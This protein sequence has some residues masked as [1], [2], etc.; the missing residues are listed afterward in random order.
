MKIKKDIDYSIDSIKLNKN[1]I[2]LYGWAA[3]EDPDNK[4]FFD[5]TDS[6][7][8]YVKYRKDRIERK[9][10]SALKYGNRENSLYG[11]AL[12][13]PYKRNNFYTLTFY[14]DKDSV[15]LSISK[16]F[17]N[18]YRVHKA[19]SSIIH[20]K[21]LKNLQLK[22]GMD[23]NH[24]FKQTSPDK[25]E[26]SLEKH[27]KFPMNAP[28]FSIVVPLY[29]TPE[30]Y[31]KALIGSFLAQTYTNFEVCFADGS[32]EDK[33]L[34]TI[35]QKYS[36]HDSRIK[37]HFIGENR[38]IS[39][40]TNEALHMAT[41]DFIVLCDHD[42]LITPNAL[43]EFAKAI[44]DN[45]EC[46]SIY[47]DEDK[48]SS[49]GKDLFDPHFK[50]DFNEDM[51]T[52]VNYICH[53][54]G[55]R[56]S[57]VQKFGEFDSSYDGAQ[58]YDFIFRMTEHSKQIVHVA[59]ILY[60]WRTHQNSTSENPES[61]LYAY[62]AGAKAIRAHYHRVHPE[63]EIERIEKGISLGI[64]HTCF[65]FKEQ[66]FVSVIIPNKD[67][68]ADLD[69]VIRS[70]IQKSTWKSL[71]FIIVENNSTDEKTFT[72]YDKIEQEFP[73]VHVVRYK[74]TF[75]FSKICNFGASKAK[76]DYLLFMNNDV[77]LI[78]PDSVL[79]MMG[80][81]QRTDVGVV[82]CRL[83]YDDNTIQHAGVVVGIG[84]TADHVFR[85]HFSENDTYFNR[86][87]IAQDYSAV[88]A[89][90]MMVRRDAFEAAGRFD[91]NLAVAF[92]DIDFCL[93]V[94]SINKLV[95]YTPYASFHHYESKSRGFEDTFDKQVRFVSEIKVFLGKWTP[96]IKKGDPYYNPN[97]TVHNNDYSYRNLAIEEVGSTFYGDYYIHCL[98]TQTP[99]YFVKTHQEK[100]F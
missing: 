42:D 81:A 7:G 78:N 44:I 96:F 83:L 72:Y 10:V 49:N 76:A 39:G 24:W 17:L 85:G 36:H 90:V 65:K 13:F 45:P 99:E 41:G 71:E 91:E 56:K 25:K 93:K 40:N 61:K 70:L 67:H 37:Y 51:L 47:S 35:V 100:T 75:N 73:Q 60:H 43:Y 68:T 52:S 15:V 4:V 98:L 26:L 33:K 18:K 88:T 66:P 50:P 12:T 59:K 94:R 82:G 2:T 53:L 64:Y 11:F 14:N 1:T 80:Y 58:D 57:L 23:Y 46:D 87:M 32:S 27:E 95:V 29:E 79:E 89:A 22:K 63:I 84:G 16:A 77:E 55:V 20:G 69:K 19:I 54:F 3:S 38:G 28:K 97:L 5:V 74:G 34:K 31:L 62:E 92:N 9:D 48:I 21:P 30:V 8:N 86:A 6:S